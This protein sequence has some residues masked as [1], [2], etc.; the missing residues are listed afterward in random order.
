MKGHG[1]E[2]P[3]Q[4]WMSDMWTSGNS[5]WFSHTG[6]VFIESDWLIVCSTGHGW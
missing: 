2:L 3:I 6:S 1:H 5:D 4:L